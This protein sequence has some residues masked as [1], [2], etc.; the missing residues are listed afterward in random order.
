MASLFCDNEF[1]NNKSHRDEHNITSP[2]VPSASKT[3]LLDIVLKRPD[4]WEAAEQSAVLEQLE[5][6]L[7][8]ASTAQP[9]D[10]SDGDPTTTEPGHPRTIRVSGYPER[11]RSKFAKDPAPLCLRALS[12]H[13]VGSSTDPT[14][15]A[16][17][18]ESTVV[19][20]VVP[21]QLPLKSNPSKRATPAMPSTTVEP[22]RID[23]ASTTNKSNNSNN[24]RAATTAVILL[25][26]RGAAAIQSRGSVF[27]VMT[28]EPVILLC[29]ISVCILPVFGAHRLG[30]TK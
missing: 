8:L 26:L 21:P 27:K 7:S 18:P 13:I 12:I 9:K 22:A 10:P 16:Y 25:L 17:R 19:F 29:Q 2:P 6:L 28:R 20:Q 24:R 4:G 1:E 3:T 14:A 5:D 11:M 15:T 30:K 23:K